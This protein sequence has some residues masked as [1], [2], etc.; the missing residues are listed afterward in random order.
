M[1]VDRFLILATK[2]TF[3]SH[4]RGS[5][6]EPCRP[7]ILTYLLILLNI[8]D[9]TMHAHAK[10]IQYIRSVEVPSQF[11]EQLG[12]S[13]ST[14]ETSGCQKAAAQVLSYINEN[15]DPCDNF[16]QFANGKYLN[17]T[18]IPENKGSTDLYE[19]V[20]DLV[21]EQLRGILSEPLQVNDSKSM[22]LA[23]N[24]NSACLNE[25]AIEKRGLTPLIEMLDEFGGWPVLQGNTWSDDNWSWT[26]IIKKFRRIGMDTDFIFSLSIESDL[27][28]SSR[29][30]LDVITINRWIW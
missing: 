14:C 22:R 9:I 6:G 3:F 29:R 30:I 7:N 11:I 21:Q 10:S 8:S 18:R 19:T 27:K 20:S 23:K 28:N 2:K 17:N 25:Q 15:I 24:F 1:I 26:D 4:F 12:K 5:S 13:Q 16:Y